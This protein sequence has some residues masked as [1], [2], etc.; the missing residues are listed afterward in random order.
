MQGCLLQG[1]TEE[2][3]LPKSPQ[4]NPGR[5]T[6]PEKPQMGCTG[7]KENISLGRGKAGLDN[8]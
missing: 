4:E 5:A 7:Q 8:E 1:A 3:V 2:S 6:G